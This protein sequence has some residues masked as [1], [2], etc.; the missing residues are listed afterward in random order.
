MEVEREV[1]LEEIVDQAVRERHPEVG[2]LARLPR[3]P[4]EGRLFG[5]KVD[6]EE[7]IEILHIRSI[8]HFSLTISE[9]TP[10]W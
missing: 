4:E 8:L 2:R 7:A 6:L 3:S 1:G 10:K 9:Y 5:R